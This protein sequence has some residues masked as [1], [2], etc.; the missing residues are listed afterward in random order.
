M[1]YYILVSCNPH[2]FSA[3]QFG[4]IPGRGTNMATTLAHDL[5]NYANSAGFALFLCSLDA[6]GA[7]DFLPHCIILEKAI[8]IIP[9][10][11]WRILSVWY[12]NMCVC[13]RW[14]SIL[15]DKIQVKRGT[16]QGGLTSPFI[17]NLFY[18]ELIENISKC[19]CGLTVENNNFNVIYYADGI[20]LFS[21]NS[22][23]LQKMINVAD[24]SFNP[25]KTECMISGHNPFTN[26][27]SWMIDNQSVTVVP[28]IKYLG[29]ILD[30]SRGPSHK[31]SRLSAVQRAFYSLHGAGL[32]Y[33]GVS[34]TTAC[35]HAP[36]DVL[37]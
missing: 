19:N 16:K 18:Q 6:Q 11:Y 31:V 10:K 35:R 17:F 30:N 37:L 36:Q 34:P 28:S 12:K 3:C 9:D 8:N 2:E 26:E 25:T 32:K 1:E 27:P 24:L 33:R 29:T 5:C 21:N 22:S 20:L 13:I 4:F 15:G 14:N 7:F 23:G